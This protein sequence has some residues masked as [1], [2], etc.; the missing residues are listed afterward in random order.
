MFSLMVDYTL[1]NDNRLLFGGT[2]R[3]LQG[4]MIPLSEL[5]GE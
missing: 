5:K 1:D 3:G 2:Y 4:T